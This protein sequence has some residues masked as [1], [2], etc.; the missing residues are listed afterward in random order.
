[1]P[2]MTTPMG[3][4]TTMHITTPM[5]W[6]TL[7][8]AG[9]VAADPAPVATD[10]PVHHVPRAA[11]PPPLDGA[12]DGPD[13]GRVP[14]AGVELFSP[15][16]SDH[17]PRTRVKLQYDDA[18]LYL[19]FRVD[20]RYVRA[21]AGDPANQVC[22]DSCVEF[23]VEPVAGRGY[24]N[25]EFSCGGWML[26][27]YKE[28]PAFLATGARD[29]GGH[30]G[31]DAR[32]SIR[33]QHSLPA[34]IDPEIAEPTTWTLGAFIPWSVFEPALGDVRPQPGATW[35]AN[36]FKCGTK[37]SHPHWAAWSPK[38]GKVGFHEPALFGELVFDD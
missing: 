5:L 35:R 29:H 16:S 1:M 11:A 2:P 7:L 13:W 24:Y 31:A 17:R 19:L 10:A 37:T 9:A 26:A 18:G 22:H 3:V 36:F 21:V 20:D 14:A 15:K 4:T 30:L 8:A 38:S 23:F 12:W 32:R 33:I 25:F 34:Q 6:A 27:A 28:S